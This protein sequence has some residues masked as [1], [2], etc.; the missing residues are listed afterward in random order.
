MHN[1]TYMSTASAFTVSLRVMQASRLCYVPGEPRVMATFQPEQMLEKTR[2]SL[3]FGDRAP[4]QWSHMESY[5]RTG[6]AS[7]AIPYVAN[8]H[9]GARCA[10]PHFEANSK[11]KPSGHANCTKHKNPHGALGPGLLVCA[12]ALPHCLCCIS[13]DLWW[14]L[15]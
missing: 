11:K 4:E 7:F 3:P 9:G 15:L 8:E 1:L 2:R 12:S 5:F 6:A 13:S 14:H 10:L